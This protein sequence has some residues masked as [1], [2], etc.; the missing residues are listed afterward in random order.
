MLNKLKN[1]QTRV[2][3]HFRT[4]K[5]V[6]ECAGNFS[7]KCLSPLQREVM[8]LLSGSDDNAQQM[9]VQGSEV[10]A[11]KSAINHL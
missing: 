8:G 3:L 10:R 1:L 9:C 4:M 7:A 2:F 11:R 5:E 6:S